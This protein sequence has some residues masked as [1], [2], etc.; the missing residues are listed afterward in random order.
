MYV[1]ESIVRQRANENLWKGDD[2]F[3]WKWSADQ[4]KSEDRQ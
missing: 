4:K 1:N 2:Q 3:V